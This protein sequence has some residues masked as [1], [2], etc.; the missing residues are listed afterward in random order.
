MK[1]LVIGLALGVLLGSS[2]HAEVEKVKLEE[3]AMTSINNEALEIPNE[4]GR[5]VNAALRAD[6]HYLYFEAPDGSVR[7]VLIGPRG[8]IQRTRNELQLLTPEVLLI[9]RGHH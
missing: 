5:L 9:K 8:A 6:V 1:R 2:A 4:Y 7:V 3:V